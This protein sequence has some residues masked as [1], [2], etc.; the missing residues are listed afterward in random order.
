[1]KLIDSARVAIDMTIDEELQH[2][3]RRDARAQIG[4]DGLIGTGSLLF[5]GA[6]TQAPEIK[7]GDT[8]WVEQPTE[9]GNDDEYLA[10]KHQESSG[11]HR[12]FKIDHGNSSRRT[13]DHWKT[14]SR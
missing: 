7:S 13:G 3:I 9:Y 1:M 4:S 8:L 10:G 6:R 5:M 14:F 2:L 12:P 11:D